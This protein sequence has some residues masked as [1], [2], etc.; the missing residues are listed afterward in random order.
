MSDQSSEPEISK[1]ADL[2]RHS[3]GIVRHSGLLGTGLGDG[4][5]GKTRFVIA[6]GI[7]G[8]S[9]MVSLFTEWAPPIQWG[10]DAATALLLFVVLGWQWPLL[11]ALIAEAVPGLAMFPFWLLVVAVIASMNKAKADDAR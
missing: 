1:P 9:D 6:F 11:P 3:T 7:A 4:H 2:A 10:V 8:L 5:L